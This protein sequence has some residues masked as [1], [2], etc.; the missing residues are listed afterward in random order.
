MLGWIISLLSV[1]PHL[2]WR[3]ATGLKDDEGTA[4]VLLQKID[5]FA[6]GYWS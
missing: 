1:K 2:C 4:A 5:L 6:G 3:G